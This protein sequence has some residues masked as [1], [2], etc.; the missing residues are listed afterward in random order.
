MTDKQRIFCEEYIIDL[1]ATKAAERAG[2]SEKTARS[3]GQ[4]MLTKV[5]IQ[6]YIEKLKKGRSERVFISQ[7]YVLKV[8]KDTIE[9]C[10]QAEPVMVKQDGV[11]VESGEYKFDSQAVLKG[12]ELLGKHLAMF[13]DKK[14]VSVEGSVN[15][16]FEEVVDDDNDDQK[17]D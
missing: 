4:R 14:D 1:N 15:I 7:D 13:T 8:I 11:L 16:I 17:A 12:A 9:R 6:E 10:R 3:Q 5:D 2:Y